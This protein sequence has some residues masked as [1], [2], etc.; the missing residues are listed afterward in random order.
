MP[1]KKV[2]FNYFLGRITVKVNGEREQVCTRRAFQV[3]SNNC[4]RKMERRRMCRRRFRLKC[5]PEKVLS[6]LICVQSQDCSLEES[7]NW[8]D[9]SYFCPSMALSHWLEAAWT[10]LWHEHCGRHKSTVAGDVLKESSRFSQ[11]VFWVMHLYDCQ[12]RKLT[13]LVC[14]TLVLISASCHFHAHQFFSMWIY[15]RK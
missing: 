13:N 7:C 8:Q 3:R 1:K 5:S 2:L 10:W 4:E 9:R 14:G 6:G 12:T 11:S 15:K